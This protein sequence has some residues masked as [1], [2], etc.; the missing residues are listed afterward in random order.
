[1]KGKLKANK[2]E[3]M[4]DK[5]MAIMKVTGNNSFIW[6]ELC[7]ELWPHISVKAML[8]GFNN[9]EY[10]N[11]FLYQID[12]MDVAFISLTIRNDYV[13]GKMDSRP[14]GYI[15]GIYA[16]PECRNR[17]IARELVS[18]AKKWSVECGC[19]MLAS[20]C[21]LS[22]TESRLFHNKIGFTEAGVNVHFIMN[23]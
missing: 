3:F 8:D 6:A 10:K 2:F 23:I 21:Y 11:E 12:G 19:S 9:D 5:N 20:D 14:V 7:N 1:M 16:K 4:E 13:E 15:E 18:F 17:G 22:N